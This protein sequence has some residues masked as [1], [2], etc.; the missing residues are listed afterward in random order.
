MRNTAVG[1]IFYGAQAFTFFGI[2]IFLPILVAKMGIGDANFVTYLYN[3][4]MLAGVI[5]GT[6]IFNRLTRRQ[7]LVAGFAL[8]AAC[9]LIIVFWR[10]MPNEVELVIFSLFSLILSAGL[11]IEN[12]YMSELYDAT[13][14]G[15]GVG[16][17]V[18]ISRFGAAAGT[19]LLPVITAQAG[20]N[21]AMLVCGVIL[22]FAGIFCFV[23]APET[24]PQVGGQKPTQEAAK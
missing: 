6:I 8:S 24:R 10:H 19:F 2:S 5:I 7:F 14:R 21:V 12:P 22:A 3:G 11:V 15:T 17:V 9:L 1:G 13:V 4:C 18:M 20:V 23:F 16:M